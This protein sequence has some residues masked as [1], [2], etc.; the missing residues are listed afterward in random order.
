MES[1]AKNHLRK[2]NDVFQTENQDFRQSKA[3]QYMNWKRLY[4]AKAKLTCVSE[5][6]SFM[7]AFSVVWSLVSK[8]F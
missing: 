7:A 3:Y 6:S 5:V 1:C 4:L 8:S 2:F